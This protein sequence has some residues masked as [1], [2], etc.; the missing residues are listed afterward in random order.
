MNRVTIFVEKEYID[1]SV[2]IHNFIDTD[3]SAPPG[4][5]EGGGN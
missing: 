5:E 3:V 4:C 1:K 2:E